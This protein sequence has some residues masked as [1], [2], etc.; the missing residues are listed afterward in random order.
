ML[1]C[2]WSLIDSDFCIDTSVRFIMID[3][4]SLWKRPHPV[5]SWRSATVVFPAGLT[6]SPCCMSVAC[7]LQI[8]AQYYCQLPPQA[9]EPML[10]QPSRRACPPPPPSCPS[11]VEYSQVQESTNGVKLYCTSGV[12]EI[13]RDSLLS[14]WPAWHLDLSFN[15]FMDHRVKASKSKASKIQVSWH[16]PWSKASWAALKFEASAWG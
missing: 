5:K 15:V 13:M 14:L 1:L 2:Y 4:H 11:K 12:L 16:A 7:Q 10:T 3:P 8:Q 9:S 6:V